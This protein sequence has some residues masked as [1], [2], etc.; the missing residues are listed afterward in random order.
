MITPDV[1]NALNQE[2]AQKYFEDRN[3]HDAAAKQYCE[4]FAQ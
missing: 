4:N 1:H 2:V 3:A